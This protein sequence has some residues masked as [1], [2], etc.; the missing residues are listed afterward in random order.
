MENIFNFKKYENHNFFHVKYGRG[1]VITAIPKDAEIEEVI[2]RFFHRRDKGDA[3]SESTFNPI[4]SI[5]ESNGYVNIQFRVSDENR[6]Y[7]GDE[8]VCGTIE[9]I[10][11]NEQVTFEVVSKELTS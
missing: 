10:I 5:Q 4:S 2:A 9:R 1:A 6:P 7:V 3:Y 8:A 11:P